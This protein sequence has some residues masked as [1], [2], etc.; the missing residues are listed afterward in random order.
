MPLREVDQMKRVTKPATEDV[1]WREGSSPPDGFILWHSHVKHGARTRAS[2]HGS[3]YRLP[4]TSSAIAVGD[5]NWASTIAST[6]RPRVPLGVG[7]PLDRHRIFHR[8]GGVG[9]TVTRASG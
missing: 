1:A 5:Q 7:G 9:R 6:G 3:R 4:S 2:A 8:R